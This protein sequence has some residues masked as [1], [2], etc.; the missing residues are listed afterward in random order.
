M[1]ISS[2]S[3]AVGLSMVSAALFVATS[4]A[5][6]AYA[7][8]CVQMEAA[9]EGNDHIRYLFT[10][11]C[12]NSVEFQIISPGTGRVCESAL[13]QP[14]RTRSMRQ[15]KVCT[16]INDGIRGCVCERSLRTLETELRQ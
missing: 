16:S 14:G 11:E 12:P 8:R 10:N 5:T 6:S 15:R 3:V 1:R 9:S 4:A 2:G 13:L 7:G